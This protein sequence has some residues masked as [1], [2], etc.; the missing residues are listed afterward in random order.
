[1]TLPKKGLKKYDYNIDMENHIVTLPK[2]GLK[3]GP[4]NIDMN[5]EDHIVTLPKKG[6]KTGPYNIDMEKMEKK[7]LK[8]LTKGQLIELLLKQKKSKKPKVVIVDDTKPTRL[9][10]PPPKPEV[11][12]CIKPTPPPR[13]GKWENVKP[14]PVPRKSVKQMVKEYEDIIQPPEQF[15]DKPIPK[16]RT[17][18]RPLQM[19]RYPKPTRKPPSIPQVEDYII[20]P[21]EQFRDRRPQKPTRKP[22]PITVPKIKELNKAIKGHAKSYGIE[23]QDDSKPLNHFTKTK[24]LVESHLENLLKDMRGFKFIETLEITFEKYS[25]ENRVSI[26]KTAFFNGKA[27]TITKADDIE[28]ELSMSRQDILNQIDQWVSEGSGWVID[29]IDSHHINVTTYTPLH[30]SNYIKLPMELKNPKKGL[31]NIKNKDDE[32]F[33]WCHI[34]HLNPQEKN[35]Q[36]I[37]KEDKEM[38]NELNYEGIEF[39]VSQKHY[40]KVEKQNNIR[41]NVFGYEIGQPFP[42]HISKETFEDQMNLLLITEY[43]KKHYVLIKDFNAFMYNQSKHKERKHFCMY[44]LQ[45]FSSERILADHANNCL[46]ING[47]QAINMPKPGKNILN[48]KNFYKQLPAPFVIYADFEAITK[49]VQGCELSEDMKNEKNK[50]SYTEA[51]QT[52]EDCGSAYKVVCCYDDKY[53]KD[54]CIYRG[55]NAVYKFMEQMLEEVKY[56]KDVIKKN[57]NKP[58]VMTEDDEMRFKQMD[59][60]YI[61]GEKYVEKDVRVR[62]HCHITGK[63]RG[64]AHRECNLKLRIK[65]EDI[66]IPVIFHNLRGYDSHF[67]MQQIGEIA[68][69]HG[70]EQDL[71]INAIP[72]NMEKYMAFMLGNN[73]TFID[74]FQF[75]GSSLDKLVNNLPKDDLKYTSKVFKGRK[76]NLLSQKGVYPYD[77]MDSFEKFDQMKLPTKDQFYSILNDQHITD[78]E[79]DHAKKVWKAFKIK[80][81]GEYHDLYL[82]SDVLLLADVFESF[83]KTCL[84]Y[85]KLDPC[86]YFTS[87]GLSWDAMLKMT[88]IKLELMTDIDMYQFIKKGLRGGVSYI[89]HRYGKANN[90]YMKE[91]NEKAPSKYIMYLD[92]NNLYGWAMSQH[93]PT[94]NFKWMS[95][96]EISK[97]DLGKY[98]ADGKKGLIL[99]VD[100]EYPQE[101]HDLH[102]DYP[103]AP[104]KMKVSTGMLS[105][106]CKKIAD[107]Y[108]ISIGL[109]SKL[110][111]MLRDKKEYVLHYRN[112]QLYLDLG[113]K[114][115][116]VHHVLQFNQSPWIKQYIDFNTKKRK[117]A[118][119]TFEKDFFKL[120]NNSVFGKTMENLRKRVD[121]RLVTNEKK[122]D[123]LTSKPTYVSSKIFNENL[124]AVHKIKET[125]TLNR[126]AY[127]GMCILDISK[128]LMYDFH[129]EYIKKKYHD[130]AKLLFTDT[131]SLTYEIEA[132]DIYNDFWTDKDM[133]DNS[134]YPESSPYYCNANKKIIGKFKD[135]ACGIPIT[136]FVG[137]KSK[138]YSYVK[139][140]EKGEKIAKG[141]KKSVIKNNIKHEDYK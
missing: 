106:Y 41:I 105:E 88:N 57:F 108:N 65:P 113:L 4:Y 91:Y 117:H 35:P 125:L 29:R 49:K 97:I 138:M 123:K 103:L 43:E 51:Y 27:K 58:L 89:A 99:E 87:P 129:Y 23:L 62:D 14:K 85:Y 9:N 45:C 5:K 64:S 120:M 72:N 33:R 42:I 17:D 94:G 61:C 130:R 69:K 37:K 121:V 53:S 12:Q 11:A 140:N 59:E 32:C 1:M 111:P 3:T 31:I 40:N 46:T 126:P 47:M 100:L 71:K 141:I 133:F 63:F 16:P 2:K 75:M 104:E 101:L 70:D 79:Y 82:G 114:I 119:N 80:T 131:D 86:H 132:E 92:A 90:K 24:E 8:K 52:H 122:L 60:C 116:K 84:K 30:G 54:I 28:H 76:L 107:K 78:D 26:Y 110:V 77:F 112:L 56:C 7:D 136:E 10:R 13:T 118:K 38:I 102:N 93:L 20:Q 134:D 6:L 124:V 48:F 74:S 139:D 36:R 98:R 18:Y 96:K 19:K 68:K 127:V 55:E 66:K 109:V 44:C 115:K 81:M 73:L 39:P 34:R 22:P 137:L 25:I 50:R 15:R 21:P 67:I 135:E 95:E 128:T 83:R